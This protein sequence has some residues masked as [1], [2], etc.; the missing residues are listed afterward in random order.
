MSVLTALGAAS[1]LVGVGLMMVGAFVSVRTETQSRQ[2]TTVRISATGLGLG[3]MGGAGLMLGL[4][5]DDVSW[6]VLI[7]AIP[8]AAMGI[9]RILWAAR[10]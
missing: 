6:P 9:R 5:Y 8:L 7:L 4:G 1:M 2:A 10:H 3:L